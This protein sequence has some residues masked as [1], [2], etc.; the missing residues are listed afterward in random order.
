MVAVLSH[1]DIRCGPKI[2][3][4]YPSIEITDQI[5][6]VTS[7][8]MDNKLGEGFYD[9]RDKVRSISHIFSIESPR[10]RGKVETLTLSCIITENDPNLNQYKEKILK[11]IKRIKKIPDCWKAFYGDY[12]KEKEEIWAKLNE[13]VKDLD[14][15]LREKQSTTVGY[16]TDGKIVYNRGILPVPKT[17]KQEMEGE[18]IYQEAINRKFLV[19]YKE[20]IDGSFIVRSHLTK[21]GSVWKFQVIS[22]KVDIFISR[23]VTTR[24]NEDLGAEILA[25]SGICQGE[26]VCTFEVYFEYEGEKEKISKLVS[27][28]KGEIKTK[29][30][31]YPIF[32]YSLVET[33]D[34][35]TPP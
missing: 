23:T 13:I 35:L 20:N 11:A 2:K 21:N 3:I 18:R 22:D 27:K 8:V 24:I 25:T 16:M 17:I 34:H 15:D 1:F 4:I 33:P 6:A 26:N 32:F 12:K 30:E 7:G 10:Q 29:N 14:I 5:Q 9:A 31:N 28:L 19:V